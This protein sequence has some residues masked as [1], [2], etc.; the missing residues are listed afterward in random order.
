MSRTLIAAVA[1]LLLAV[2]ATIA[3]RGVDDDGLHANIRN[4]ARVSGAFFLF[5]FVT[6]RRWPRV[7]DA[8][9]IALA[10]SHT[11]HAV[12]ILMAGAWDLGSLVALVIYAAIY[13][14]AWCALR[15]RH[16]SRLESVSRYAVWI[17]FVLAFAERAR[18]MPVYIGA[19]ALFLGVMVVHIITFRAPA[20]S[21]PA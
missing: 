6:L 7:S 15:G 1:V 19:V 14:L 16:G 21:L 12:F 10:I 17:A 5:G 13:Y 11:V 18:F 3:L 9:F 20:R 2:G 8:F 4:T